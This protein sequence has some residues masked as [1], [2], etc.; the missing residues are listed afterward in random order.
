MEAA[1]AHL[2]SE[3]RHFGALKAIVT[4]VSIEDF[5]MIFL[6]R[7]SHEGFV[8]VSDRLCKD[9]TS[10]HVSIDQEK[11]SRLPEALMILM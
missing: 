2:C 8:S 1:L 3:R 11:I 6:D 5:A 10:E 4:I 7:R 9:L